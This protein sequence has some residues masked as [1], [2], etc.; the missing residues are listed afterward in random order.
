MSIKLTRRTVTAGIGAAVAMP[1]VSR[2]AFAVDPIVIGL[3]TA[4]TAPVEL[5]II[6]IIFEVPSSR[7]RKSTVLA[8]Y[9]V[10]S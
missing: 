1:W 9:W 3:P 5:L 2:S 10:V 4:Q 7:W 8:E 6:S